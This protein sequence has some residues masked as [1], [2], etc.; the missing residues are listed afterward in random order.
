ME[1]E[2]YLVITIPAGG[3]R[4]AARRLRG[5]GFESLD[6]SQGPTELTVAEARLTP[7][8]AASE[9]RNPDQVLL[10][11][12]AVDLIAPTEEKDAPGST[13]SPVADAEMTWGLEAIGIAGSPY[14]GAG[15]TVAVLDTGIDDEDGEGKRYPAFKGLE[16][17]KK[18]FTG[19]GAKDLDGHGTH[20]AGTIAGREVPGRPR[21]GVAPGIDRLLVGKVIPMKGKGSSRAVVKAIQWAMQEGAQVISMSLVLDLPGMVERLIGDGWPE[22]LA[23]SKALQ[24]YQDNVQAFEALAKAGFAFSGLGA[25]ALLVA[26]AGNQ[27]RRGIDKSFSLRV[28]PPAAAPGVLSVGALEATGEPHQALKPAPFSN[29]GPDISGPG[30]DVLS[31]SL[32]GSMQLSSGT[33]M[34]TPHVAGLAALWWQRTAQKSSVVLART[35]ESLLVGRANDEVFVEDVE[36]AHVGTGLAQA[37]S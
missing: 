31:T 25:G 26:A 14:D 5:I 29:T 18:D 15:V 12:L 1:E 3:G 8:Q 20:C 19:E 27:S 22:E 11:D 9:R 28:S 4:A 6:S 32:A 36:H 37:P 17:L 21:F 13:D 35:V 34:A 16:I 24:T 2:E 33:S 30:V 10:P 7:A 23:T